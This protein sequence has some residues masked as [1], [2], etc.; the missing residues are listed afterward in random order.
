MCKILLIASLAFA[1]A[2]SGEI[3]R[4]FAPTAGI[5]ADP[6]SGRLIAIEGVGGRLNLG[7]GVWLTAV[8]AAWLASE[9]YALVQVDGAWKL[10]EWNRD[11]AL[12]R[13]V[14]LGIQDWSRVVWNPGG[15][16]W[17]ACGDVT[18]GCAV[19]RVSDGTIIRRIEAKEKL[20]AV[21]TA[22]LNGAEVKDLNIASYAVDFLSSD[23]SIRTGGTFQIDLP[24]PFPA[25]ANAFSVESLR[26]TLQNR[27]GSST[28]R[29]ARACN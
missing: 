16:A 11:W 24:L 27:V 10:L 5:V 12:T 17:L 6:A 26:I 14:E 21:A 1:G 22:F 15:S 20:G 19:H 29:S 28:E 4:V 2:L 25:S 8:E 13:T 3:T 23:L 9:S 18:P 7:K